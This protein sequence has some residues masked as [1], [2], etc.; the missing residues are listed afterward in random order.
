L[1][2]AQGQSLTLTSLPRSCKFFLVT[3][4][5]SFA[6]SSL[7]TKERVRYSNHLSFKNSSTTH[8]P[9]AILPVSQIIIFGF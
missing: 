9:A 3:S 1:A 6:A 7:T 8:L 4:I 2:Q 5:Q